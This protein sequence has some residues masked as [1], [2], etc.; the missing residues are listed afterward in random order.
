MFSA[1][2][3]QTLTLKKRRLPVPP[4][5]VVLLDALVDG[6]AEVGDRGAVLGEPEFGVVGEVADLDGEVVACHQI[7]QSCSNIRR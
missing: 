7:L 1:C 3:R 2:S 5:P 4:G 6:Q